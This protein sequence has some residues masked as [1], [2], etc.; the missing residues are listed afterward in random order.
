[1]NDLARE[2]L[3]QKDPELA[4]LLEELNPFKSEDMFDHTYTLDDEDLKEHA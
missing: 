3:R 1:M 2:S 4:Q